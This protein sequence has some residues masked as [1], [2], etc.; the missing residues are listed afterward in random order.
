MIGHNSVAQCNLIGA[1]L[2][3]LDFSGKTLSRD[4]S[5]AAYQRH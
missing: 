4:L 5:I 1:A 3:R 2:D